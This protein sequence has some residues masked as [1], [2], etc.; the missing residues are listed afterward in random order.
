V[1]RDRWPARPFD[2]RGLTLIEILF[3]IVI[4]GVALAGLGI[5]VPVGTLGVHDG[6]QRTTATFLAEQLMERTRAAAWTASPPVDCLGLSHG[7][8]PPVPSGATCH[9]EVET[10]FPDEPEVSGHPGYRRTV[11]VTSCAT[12]ACAGVTTAGLRLV[13]VSV[14]YTPLAGVGAGPAGSSSVQLAWLVS[15]K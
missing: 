8:T 9:D 2:Q 7:D 15:R 10:L 1:S 6:Q 3:A 5:V 11:R 12:I 13:E 4:L 14:A